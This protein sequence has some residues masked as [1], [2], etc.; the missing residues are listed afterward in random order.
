LVDRW[1]EARPVEPDS[2]PIGKAT[3]APLVD[4]N[5]VEALEEHHGPDKAAQMLAAIKEIPER[6]ERMLPQVSDRA[7]IAADADELV[8]VARN[9]GLKE[10]T[11]QSRR[12]AEVDGEADDRQVGVMVENVKT[13]AERAI[14]AI[15]RTERYASSD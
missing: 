14:A 10:L 4:N 9:L 2:A 8:A 13:A 1:L 7:R 15:R 6:L 11:V 12:L 5:V 3:Q